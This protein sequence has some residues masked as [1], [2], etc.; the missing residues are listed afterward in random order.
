MFTYSFKHLLS[1]YYNPEW[2][3]GIRDRTESLIHKEK[4]ILPSTIELN[5]KN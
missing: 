3:L 4:G 2:I 5:L 1:I